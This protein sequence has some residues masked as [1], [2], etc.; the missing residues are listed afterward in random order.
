M[1]F[2]LFLFNDIYPAINKLAHRIHKGIEETK[3]FNV[4]LELSDIETILNIMI[5]IS[6]IIVMI[7]FNNLI[8]IL[9]SIY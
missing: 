3:E 4:P 6:P 9:T 5:P 1:S 2:Y 8:F 7:I